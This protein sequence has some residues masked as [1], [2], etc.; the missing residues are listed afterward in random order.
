METSVAQLSGN[1]GGGDD[2]G[3]CGEGG[4]DG[5]V[6]HGMSGAVVP[7]KRKLRP[8][9]RQHAT[10]Y[11]TFITLVS[12]NSKVTAVSF[13]A[14][15]SVG[16]AGLSWFVP[17]LV[18]QN[19]GTLL[20][21]DWAMAEPAAKLYWLCAGSWSV[22]HSR[23]AYPLPEWSKSKY[24]KAKYFRPT[25]GRLVLWSRRVKM[26]VASLIDEPAGKSRPA[27]PPILIWPNT[28]FLLRP[29]I[30]VPSFARYSEPGATSTFRL[31][32]VMAASTASTIWN[33]IV[34]PA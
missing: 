31:T 26:K 6:S 15:M 3:G 11:V 32:W 29:L 28:L 27:L 24:E 10:E 34:L 20:E 18:E 17:H 16:S 21:T 14:P 33:E 7:A 1:G 22:R 23:P 8:V 2:D 25:T 13:T 9:P 12:R 30:L 4:A 19:L 5:G